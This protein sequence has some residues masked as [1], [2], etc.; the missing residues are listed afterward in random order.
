MIGRILVVDDEEIERVSIQ[1]QLVSEGYEVDICKDAVS[2]LR[3]LES[4]GDLYDVILS[5]IKMPQMDG[6]EFLKQ[7]K[8]K[9]PE[10]MV[11]LMTA[12]ARVEDA[13]KSM[14]EGAFDYITKPFSIEELS[15][16]LE[17]AMEYRNQSRENTALKAALQTRYRFDN[18]VGKSAVMQEVFDRIQTVAPTNSTALIQGE[19]GTGKEMAALAIH[20][21]SPRRDKPFIKVSCAA[22][23]KELLE[24]ELFGHEAGAFTSAI[25]TR[26]G[27]FE[28]AH[29]GTLFL[30]EVDDIPYELQVKLLRAIEEKKFER[31]GG[32]KLMESDVRIIAA[33][34]HNLKELVDQKKVRPDLFY[35][36][37]VMTINLPPLRDR[38]DDIPFL[39]EH[40]LNKYA[41]D[42]AVLWKNASPD[43]M[44]YLMDYDWPGNVRE[45]QNV[46][47]Q[48]TLVNKGGNFG[49]EHL[50]E[51]IV[52]SKIIALKEQGHLNL[53]QM[54]SKVERDVIDWALKKADGNQTRAAEILGI[55]RTTLRERVERLKQ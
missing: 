7:A 41:P 5:D 50:P 51:N 53:N 18:L 43:V 25:K 46:I 44:K 45:L 4:K 28:L 9:Y 48:M 55:P 33:S 34:K 36:L 27:R 29:T 6:L 42:K 23:S 35:R 31:V 47:E 11:I 13:V 40:F 10:I 52:I 30:D 24:S 19:T 26:R 20:Y 12:Y 2:A 22:L 15:V 1:A 54:L 16:K 39:V 37:S 3:E 17:H 8:V 14:R 38:K 32:E 21:N 49:I